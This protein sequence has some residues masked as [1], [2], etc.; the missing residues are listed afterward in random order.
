MADDTLTKAPPRRADVSGVVE[1][2][3]SQSTTLDAWARHEWTNGV[4]LESL[5]PLHAAAATSSSPSSPEKTPPTPAET[6]PIPENSKP[7]EEPTH[8]H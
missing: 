8:D 1:P 2:R 7:Q 4:Q 3:P 5:A 6:H